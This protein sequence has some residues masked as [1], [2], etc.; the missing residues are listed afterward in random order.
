M[1]TFSI[2]RLDPFVINLDRRTDRWKVMQQEL[3]RINLPARRFS[4]M[5]PSEYSET[6][7][8]GPL[9]EGKRTGGNWASMVY[10]MR[11][12]QG[13]DR[14]LLMLED[15][16][17]FCSDWW[18]RMAWLEDNLDFPWDVLFLGA[19]FHLNRNTE[20]RWHPER[21]NDVERT[22]RKHLFRAYGVW[23]NHGMIVRG[24][25]AGKVLDAMRS[26]LPVARGSDHALILA[27]P[28]LDAVVFVPGCVFQR[29]GASDVAEGGGFTEFSNFKKLGPYVFQDRLA[30]WDVDGY[31][32]A[33]ADP[34]PDNR[35]MAMIQEKQAE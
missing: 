24:E 22:H 26:V 23:S 17:Y 29:D 16:V 7:G 5:E 34:T 8:A 20:T 19:C 14:D 32:W 9:I 31:D 10:L 15:D 11:L 30:D 1:G 2:D 3:R 13:T 27:Q 12:N 33:E 28:Q 6:P 35:F 18:E 25:S 4:A 21:T